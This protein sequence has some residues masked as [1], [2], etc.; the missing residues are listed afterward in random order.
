MGFIE[1]LSKIIPLY[2]QIN[3]LYTFKDG[4]QKLF[5]RF[6]NGRLTGYWT[7]GHLCQD[8]RWGHIIYELEA[9][10]NKQRKEDFYDSQKQKANKKTDDHGSEKF[11]QE[12]LWS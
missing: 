8:M 10:Q 11:D 9:Q 1:E 7:E 12:R 3:N 2:T 4:E 6:I 5:V